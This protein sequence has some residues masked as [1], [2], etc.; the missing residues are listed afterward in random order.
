MRRA[1]LFAVLA[2]LVPVPV[3]VGVIWLITTATGA[4]WQLVVAV[5]ALAVG[6]AVLARSVLFGFRQAAGPIGELIE[7]SGRV[8]AGELGVQV[9][10]QGVREIRALTRAFNTMSTR[11]AATEEQ[12]RSLLAEI[13]HELRTPLTVIEGN[14][15]AMLDGVY[16]TDREHLELIQAQTRQLERLI[17]DLRTLSLA[18]TGQLRLEREPTDLA[19]L[20]R[21]VVAAFA[22]EAEA[23]GVELAVEASDDGPEVD[24]DGRRVHQVIS[25]LITNALR[26][27]TSGGQVIVAVAAHG[28]GLRLEVA[29]TGS[30]M[31]P[32]A[33]AH[34]FE[35]FWRAGESAG[36]GLGLTIVHDLV[37][38]HGG[39]VE[40]RSQEDKGTTVTCWFP[41]SA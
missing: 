18:E 21:D 20:A 28:N 10:E 37:T 26:H 24:L 27:T 3:I 11:L 1:G 8:E 39:T 30:G 4:G 14:V 22:A 34:A 9:P 25:N 19:A 5:L 17:E 29:D 16:L 7:A 6:V 15:E 40:L 2:V 12:R 35:R 31:A 38:A 36:A 41:I 23:A 32:E 33:V 13:G